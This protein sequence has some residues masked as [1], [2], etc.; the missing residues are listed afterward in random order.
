VEQDRLEQNKTFFFLFFDRSFIERVKVR[1]R[2]RSISRRVL[3]VLLK[4]Q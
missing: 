1:A 3:V 4:K 2:R